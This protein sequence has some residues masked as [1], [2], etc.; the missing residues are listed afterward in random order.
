MS[1]Q[2]LVLLLFFGQKILGLLKTGFKSYAID[3]HR[4][5][6]RREREHSATKNRGDYSSTE[7]TQA[8]SVTAACARGSRRSPAAP[9]VVIVLIET[10]SSSS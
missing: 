2:E 6:T 7:V 3:A 10:A 8:R 4:K 1:A 5:R 9:D